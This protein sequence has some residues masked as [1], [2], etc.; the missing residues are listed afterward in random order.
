MW[1]VRGLQSY[2]TKNGAARN[3]VDLATLRDISKQTSKLLLLCAFSP[4]VEFVL[5][6]YDAHLVKTGQLSPYSLLYGGDLKVYSQRI[7]A[8]VRALKHVGVSPV[9]FLEC[10][11]GANPKHFELQFPQLCSQHEEVLEQCV[12]VHQG[13]EGAGSLAGMHAPR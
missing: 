10:S 6:A 5:S 1:G 8:F 9:I 13:C 12:A 11:P 3:K 7:L 4:V 2:I